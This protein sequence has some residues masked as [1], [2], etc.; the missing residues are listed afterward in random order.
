MQIEVRGDLEVAIRSL[1]KVVERDGIHKEL[2]I[3]EQSPNRT[4]RRKAKAMIA[5]RRRREIEKKKERHRVC[6]E[7]SKLESLA[8]NL[9]TM[10]DFHDYYVKALAQAWVAKDREQQKALRVILH[11]QVAFLAREMIRA[12]KEECGSNEM[13]Q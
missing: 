2:K 7:L 13:V 9:E 11:K 8:F 6:Y 5:A 3:R 4:D 12:K 1:K 10:D